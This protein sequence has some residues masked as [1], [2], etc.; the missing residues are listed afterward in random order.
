MARTPASPA[1]GLYEPGWLASLAFAALATLAVCVPVWPGF[2]SFD[3]VF[4]YRQAQ[5]SVQTM[6]WP[7][8]HTYMFWLSDRIGLGSGGVLAFQVFLLFAAAAVILHL[9]VRNRMAA[10]LLCGLFAAL[11]IV[12]PTLWGSMLVHWRDVPTTSFALAGVA[13]WLLAARYGAPLLLAPAAAAFGCAV[14]LRYNAVVLIA[15]V[16]LAMAWAPLLGRPSRFARPFAI[17]CICAALATAWAS[18]QWRLPDLKR[19]PTVNGFVGTQAFDLAGISACADKSYLPLGMT[20]GVP[21]SAYHIRRNY[22][23]QHMNLTFAP[24]PGVPRISDSDRD[25][26]VPAAWRDA[27]LK[28][29]GCYLSHR[30]TV[31]VEQMGVAEKGVFYAT[32]AMLDPNPYGLTLARK[33]YAELV[34]GHVI[35]WADAPWRRPA[36]LYAIAAALTGIAL[37]R[38]RRR[39]P[40]LLA[41]LGGAFA[42]AGVLFLISPAADARYIFPSNVVCALLIAASLGIIAQGRRA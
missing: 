19:M 20:G 24:K 21:L 4:A 15:F 31:F 8:L 5:E 18:T 30:T 13:F 42:Y 36:W 11:F 35:L 38:D 10:L 17:L 28:E 16:L 25:G 40:L 2:M 7:P 39:A 26:K 22:N 33:P 23:P 29:P 3:S 14:A 27:I 34:A 41:L 9:L 1:D 32:H 12:F 6:I 37:I